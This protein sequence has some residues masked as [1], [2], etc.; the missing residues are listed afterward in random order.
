M[1]AEGLRQGYLTQAQ[2]AIECQGKGEVSYQDGAIKQCLSDYLQK[3]LDTD[4][5]PKTPIKTSGYPYNKIMKTNKKQLHIRKD[6]IK[7]NTLTDLAFKN[8]TNSHTSEIEFT[9]EQY[10]KA[11]TAKH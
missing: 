11:K 1:S 6:E 3:Q 2:R 4:I 9:N 10:L 7:F 8:V 5:K